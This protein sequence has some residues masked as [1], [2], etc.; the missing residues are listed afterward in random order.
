[1]DWEQILKRFVSKAPPEASGALAPK[2]T[3][4]RQKE[5]VVRSAVKD[6]RTDKAKELS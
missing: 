1:M 6:T 2:D 3:D 4:W 5:R